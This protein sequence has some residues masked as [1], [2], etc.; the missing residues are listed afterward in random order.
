MQKYNNQRVFPCIFEQKTISE[1]IELILAH[2]VWQA[3]LLVLKHM[4]DP[5]YGSVRKCVSLILRSWTPA[6]TIS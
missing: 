4:E 2:C 5:V 6:R 3:K 1:Q